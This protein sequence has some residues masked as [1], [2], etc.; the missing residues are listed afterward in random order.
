MKR[1]TSVLA[2][3]WDLMIITLA[4]ALFLMVCFDTA[5]ARIALSF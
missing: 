5:H 1:E 2:G 4:L 3:T